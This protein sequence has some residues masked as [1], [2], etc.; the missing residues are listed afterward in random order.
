[1][2]DHSSWIMAFK[3]DGNMKRINLRIKLG[4]NPLVKEHMVNAY[5]TPVAGLVIH[6]GV[7]WD[8]AEDR[9]IVKRNCWVIT[10]YPTGKMA[11]SGIFTMQDALDI[12]NRDMAPFNWVGLSVED[13]IAPNDAIALQ[14]LAKRV[15]EQISIAYKGH[16]E[17]RKK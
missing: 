12:V 4:R 13:V 3:G 1:M 6:P 9:I 11:F 14:A 17:A 10:Q 8:G 7:E 2:A 5:L 15:N 16:S